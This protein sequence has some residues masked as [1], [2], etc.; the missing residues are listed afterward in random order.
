LQ[1]R[2]FGPGQ[3][4]LLGTHDGILVVKADAKIRTISGRVSAPAGNV[5]RVVM[6][7]RSC[8][9]KPKRQKSGKCNQEK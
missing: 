7:V 5:H 8:G 2:G 4:A 6:P 1:H 9:R 3:R